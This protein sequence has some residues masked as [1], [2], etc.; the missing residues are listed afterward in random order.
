MAFRP[1]SLLRGH[2]AGV[3]I[4]ATNHSWTIAEEF[5]RQ[6]KNERRNTIKNRRR[7]EFWQHAGGDDKMTTES[8]V[9]LSWCVPFAESKD[10]AASLPA[11]SS[12]T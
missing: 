6:W 2:V 4:K 12:E 8:A 10:L 5:A 11:S 9:P 7:S 1:S 3:P